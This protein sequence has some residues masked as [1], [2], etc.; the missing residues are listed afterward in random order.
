MAGAGGSDADGGE[1]E[2]EPPGGTVE[3][4]ISLPGE[5]TRG[6]EA[7]RAAEP[8]RSAGNDQCGK[9][10]IFFMLTASTGNCDGV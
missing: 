8:E 2:D 4:P 5:H 6:D 10:I 9:I 1:I 3:R 7:A